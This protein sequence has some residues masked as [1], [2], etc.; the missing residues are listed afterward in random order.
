M[1]RAVDM[2][3]AS[4][5]EDSYTSQDAKDGVKIEIV[6]GTPKA[7]N[8]VAEITSSSRK[9]RIPYSYTVISRG[10]IHNRPGDIFWIVFGIVAGVVAIAA[11][12][13][14]FVYWK[15]KKT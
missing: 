13:I 15:Y 1:E 10:N 12:I 3:K 2:D 8:I 4:R 5:G 7:I 9:Q 11:G 6:R 14:G